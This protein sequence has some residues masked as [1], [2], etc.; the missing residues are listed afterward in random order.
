[1]TNQIPE[2]VIDNI[3]KSNDIVDI[4][5]EY[6]QL[7]KSGRNFFGLCPFHGEK[8]PSF[9]V[10][11]EKQIFHCFGC[12]KGGNVITFMME[13]EGFSFF[14]ALK[15]LSDR[16]GIEL[17]IENKAESN[18]SQD[19][20][21]LLSAYE[22]LSKLYHHLL[23]HSKD[24]KEGYHY[25]KERGITDETI[26]LF[27]LG[28]APNLKDF[29]ATFLE[30]KGF[31]LQTLVRAGLLTMRD[32]KTITDRFR[33]RVIF[34]IRNHLGKTIA[35]GGRAINDDG[36]KY[37]NSSESELFQKGRMLFN[38][39]LAKKHIRTSNEV[40][41]FEGYMDVISAYQAGIK[42]GIATLGTSLT[43]IQSKLLKRYVDTVVICFDSD[44]P[45]IEAAYKAATLLQKTG[46]YVKIANVR[47]GLDPDDFIKKYGAEDFKNK[48]INVSE[49]F[50]SFLMRYKKKDF[51][52]SLEGDRLKYI[53][54]VIKDLALINSQI[55]KE[56]Y[57]KELSEEFDISMNTLEDELARH[58]QTF[59]Q[60]KDKEKKDRYTNNSTTFYRINKLRPAFH[61]AERK[62]IA[63]MLKNRAITDKVREEIGASFNIDEHKVIAT[64]LY[65]FYE[66]G[67]EGDVSIFLE[68]IP[69]VRLKQLVT[70]I[71]MIPISEEISEREINDYIRIISTELTDTE[72]INSLREEQ[73][74]AEQQND[75]IKAAEIALKI[76][77]IQKQA[78]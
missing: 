48:V 14:D 77:N 7:K 13:I 61:N 52:L 49:T 11:Q 1:M 9:S 75:F 33:G 60:N 43:E 64:H 65:A 57:L 28:F 30:K 46:C 67:H 37:L 3:R 62:L 72:T 24:G 69:E 45:G 68:K 44:E 8:T 20:Q 27:Q 17:P 36:P 22:W 4:V 25:F 78:R 41:L 26:D 15:F 56:Y 32:D 74:V 70:E 31:H 53:E 35:F 58:H 34:P 38:F 54:L 50:M 18:L 66:E 12:G 6:V 19:N 51:N 47:D 42:N 71:A 40:I 55:E 29:T 10:T 63:Y 2:E 16:S 5:G 73:K 39:D 59:K 23:R 76:I 21:S